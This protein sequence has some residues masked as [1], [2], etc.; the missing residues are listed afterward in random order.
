ME[1]CMIALRVLAGQLAICRLR[2]GEPAPGWGVG[3]A[4][5]SLRRAGLVQV[6]QAGQFIRR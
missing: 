6:G 5:W 1:N 3:G 4:L 2:P